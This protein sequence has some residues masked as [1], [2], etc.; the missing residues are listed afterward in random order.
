MN[1]L[2]AD[3]F[4]RSLGADDVVLEEFPAL[5][6]IGMCVKIGSKVHAIR[7]KGDLVEGDVR[8]VVDITKRYAA[9][10]EAAR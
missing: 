10:A 4:A 9:E 6:E 1:M 7:V 3:E 5:G 2:E 8:T